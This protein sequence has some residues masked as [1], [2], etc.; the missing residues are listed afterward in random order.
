MIFIDWNDLEVS[1]RLNDGDV[2]NVSKEDL[3]DPSVSQFVLQLSPHKDWWKGLQLLDNTDAQ[4]AFI[5]VQAPQ[6]EASTD[7]I[8]QNDIAV[9]GKL[10]L[11]KA[12][13]FGIHTP[14]YILAD[15]ERV[16]GQKVTLQW[17]AD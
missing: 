1:K 9:G 4:I 3:G 7:P 17:N 13:T 5:E 8:S 16:A 12:K 10:V 6:R 2:I 14:M 11:W 15:L